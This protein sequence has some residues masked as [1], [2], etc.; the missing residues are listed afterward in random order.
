MTDG[1]NLRSAHGKGSGKRIMVGPAS[2]L[3]ELR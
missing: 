2:E 1:L 3:S